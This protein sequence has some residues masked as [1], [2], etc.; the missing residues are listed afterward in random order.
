MRWWRDPGNRLLFA[1]ALGKV[2]LNAAFLARYD[3]FR[4]ELYY[5]ACSQHLAWGYVDQP[6]LSIAILALTRS[7]FG[8]SL[9]AIRLPAVLAGAAA[10]V[11]TGLIARRLGGGRWAEALAALGAAL[12]PVVLGNAGRSFSMNAFDLFLWAWAAYLV[13]TILGDERPRLWLAF[14]AVAG[15]GLLNKVSM[16]FF[17]FGLAVG[18][19]LTRARRELRSPWFWA[20]GLLAGLLFLPHLLW[21]VAHGWPTLEF[22]RAATEHKNVALAPSEFFLKQ[23]LDTGFAQS[24]LWL[25]G[26]AWLAFHPAARQWR[27]FALL[28]PAIFA[29]MVANGAKAYYLSPV[30]FPLLAAGAVAFEGWTGAAARWRRALRSVFAVL[31]VGLSAIAVPF[32]IPA[33]SPEGFIAY[34]RALGKT[35]KA[36]ER[37]AVAELPQYY[38]DEFGWR[39]LAAQVVGIYRGLTPEEQQGAAIFVRNYGEAAAI[40]FFGREAGLPPALCG[41][42]SYWLWGPGERNR[43][44]LIIL[45]SSRDLAENL[46][47]LGRPDR[48]GKVELVGTTDCRYCMPYERGRQLFLCRDPAFDF[49]DIWAEERF[50]I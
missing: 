5:L 37:S 17:G 15:L 12:A 48:C 42:N 36:E 45:G 22:M 29:V 39:E 41:H 14:G 43:S 19:L 50:F 1:I 28:Y 16:L 2:A 33:L 9:L 44:V 25:L 30:Y 6:P 26:L 10:V 18:L 13:V 38:A 47:D 3:Y 7:L 20:G 34:S 31:I 11:L 46:A 35:P 21:Q 27:A 32:A 4:D 24:A 49:A 23:I 40:D 8:D